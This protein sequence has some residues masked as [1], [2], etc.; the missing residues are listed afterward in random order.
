VTPLQHYRE[1]RD[2]YNTIESKLDQTRNRFL[3]AKKQDQKQMLLD[4]YMFALCSIQT[5]VNRHEQAFQDYL[6]GKTPL[7]AMKDRAVL[8]HNNKNKYFQETRDNFPAIS[9]TVQALQNHQIDKAHRLMVDN[10]KGV[11]VVKSAFV[12]AMM[13][14]TEKM[15]IDTN[16]KQIAMIEDVYSGVVIERYNMQCDEV[17]SHVS[18]EL[19]ERLSPFM[20]QWLLFDMNRGEISDHEV[21][22]NHVL[23]PTSDKHE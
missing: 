21:W 1:N 22:F 7:Q 8:F 3:N 5:P 19:C 12:L 2:T 15:C 20:I 18:D 6:N 17:L 23:P 4:S 14:F 10:F 11:G 9:Q 13:G 16:V